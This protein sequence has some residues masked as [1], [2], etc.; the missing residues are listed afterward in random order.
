MCFFWHKMNPT[1][2]T[3]P[4]KQKSKPSNFDK[5]QIEYF[6]EKVYI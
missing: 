4:N 5:K 1:Q 2:Q 6:L 3:K